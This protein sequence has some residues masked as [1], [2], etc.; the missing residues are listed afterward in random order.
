MNN[1]HSGHFAELL[2]LLSLF[3]KG[4]VPVRRNYVTGRGTH[5][6][7]VDLIVR[8]KRTLVFVEVKKRTTQELAA[9]A[10]QPKQQER[11]RRAAEGFLAR[12]PQYQNFDVR[13]DVVLV[14]FPLNLHHIK[15]AF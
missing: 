15:N 9:Y 14:S 11:I 10:V 4:Y 3:F 2:A 1:Y 7:E 8:Q 13:F 12:H 5:A 6:G